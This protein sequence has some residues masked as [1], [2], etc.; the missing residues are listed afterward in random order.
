VADQGVVLRYGEPEKAMLIERL[1]RKRSLLLRIYLI[2]V[3]WFTSTCAFAATEATHVAVI[4]SLW[5]T[6]ITIVP[7]LVYTVV[8]HNAIKAISPA[9][10]SMGIKQIVVSIVFF[11]PLEAGL[12]L[13]AINLWI[14]H[15]IL[16][17]WARTGTGSGNRT[18]SRVRRM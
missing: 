4:S 7:V 16:R 13:P 10:A 18:A 14:S 2:H 15:R 9:A 6:L 8:T 17:A 12:I 11:T 1:R 3:G 5:L